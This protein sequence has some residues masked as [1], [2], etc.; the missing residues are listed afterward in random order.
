MCAAR[1]KMIFAYSVTS[2]GDYHAICVISRILPQ[3]LQHFHRH[4]KKA[5]SFT[6]DSRIL[7]IFSLLASA[8]PKH[9]SHPL[10]P[11][12]PTYARA[13]PPAHIP[14]FL[15]S[16]P[17]LHSLPTCHASHDDQTPN[18]HTPSHLFSTNTERPAQITI[19]NNAI[20][21]GQN[22]P[23]STLSDPPGEPLQTQLTALHIAN[24]TYYRFITC[25][26]RSLCTFP[27]WE[28]LKSAL[29]IR[30]NDISLLNKTRCP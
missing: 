19:L 4:R 3:R 5:V 11:P 30:P 25:K 16:S 28:L 20:L 23:Q 27:R 8:S 1:I 22:N 10:L 13:L 17:K 15:W 29:A 12:T 7:K 21:N 2:D 26:G 6:T 24:T 18:I 9:P 14:A